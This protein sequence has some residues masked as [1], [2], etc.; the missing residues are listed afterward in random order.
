MNIYRLTFERTKVAEE[1]I[2]YSDNLLYVNFLERLVF[3]ELKYI[4]GDMKAKSD[5]KMYVLPHM[6]VD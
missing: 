3:K 4:C 5:L 1:W 6:K 2:C